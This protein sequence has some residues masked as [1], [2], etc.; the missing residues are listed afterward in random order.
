[1]IFDRYLSLPAFLIS[2]SIGL[3]Y[4]YFAPIETHKVTVYPTPD[5]ENTFEY[6]DKAENCFGFSQIEVAC[7]TDKSTIKKIPYQG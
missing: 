1:M 7:P 5:N 3:L 4:V 2:L 6:K